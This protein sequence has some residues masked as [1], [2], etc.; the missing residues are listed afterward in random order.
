MFM[1][2]YE[3]PVIFI[4]TCEGVKSFIA[5]VL[6]VAV[7]GNVAYCSMSDLLMHIRC[8]CVRHVWYAPKSVM[9]L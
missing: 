8:M 3:A 2:T 1:A 7:F 5:V 9:T 6:S 4:K